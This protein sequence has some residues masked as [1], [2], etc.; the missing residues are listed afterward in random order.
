MHHPLKLLNF[1]TSFS[2]AWTAF[3][4]WNTAGPDNP[5]H[6]PCLATGTKSILPHWFCFGLT[7][8]RKKKNKIKFSATAKKSCSNQQRHSALSEQRRK[9]RLHRKTKLQKKRSLPRQE[10]GICWKAIPSVQIASSFRGGRWEGRKQSTLRPRR[11]NTEKV[12]NYVR[13][14]SPHGYLNCKALH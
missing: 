11:C 5:L 6:M 14:R 9:N 2:Q 12:K 13:R 4:G 1:V 7:C 3:T 10:P 8:I